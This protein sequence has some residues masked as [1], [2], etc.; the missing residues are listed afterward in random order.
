MQG[1]EGDDDILLVVEVAQQGWGDP[2]E[3]VRQLVSRIGGVVGLATD[4]LAGRTGS[5]ARLAIQTTA[6]VVWMKPPPN[7]RSGSAGS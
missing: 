6:V 1:D 3:T 7:R 4:R 5:P 2:V